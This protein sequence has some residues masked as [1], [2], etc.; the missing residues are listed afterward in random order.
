MKGLVI[1]NTGS[2]YLV[3]TEDGRTIECKI[4]GN[5]RLKGIRSTNPIAVGDYVQII[6][7]NEGTAFISEIEDR[8]NYIIRRA[9]NLSK[10]SHILAANLDQCMLIVT[11]NY[12]ETSTIFIDLQVWKL[13][14]Q[15]RARMRRTR[16][17]GETSN[18]RVTLYFLPEY[19]G[20]QGR[21][22]VSRRLLKTTTL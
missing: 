18:Q 2:W 10:Q 15:A 13:H 7:N 3:K 21:R 12:P 6:I 17:S 22:Q 14:P 20:R 4:K 16:C 8:K 9:S 1:K 11:I 5:F 19:V